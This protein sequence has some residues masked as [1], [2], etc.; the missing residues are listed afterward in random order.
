MESRQSFNV[1]FASSGNL[2]FVVV[3]VASYVSVAAALGSARRSLSAQEI[4]VLV[5][6][7]TAYLLVGIYGFTTCRR[8]GTL[9]A[10]AIYFAIQLALAA[11]VIQI[12]A[13][14]L[15][16]LILLPLAGQ[17]VLLL[18]TRWMVVV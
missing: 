15:V 9:R 6:A 2:A 4:G 11:V 13:A 8:S 1:K 14:G 16:V 12:G 5:F 17:S 3:V 18:P 10:A 7:G